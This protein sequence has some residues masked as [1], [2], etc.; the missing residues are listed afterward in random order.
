MPDKF[1]EV[2]SIFGEVGSDLRETTSFQSVEVNGVV[3]IQITVQVLTM[4]NL[5]S[6]SEQQ[7]MVQAYF[8]E[9]M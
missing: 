3:F 6:G 2:P 8:R 5:P 7:R 9:N 1:A 4:A